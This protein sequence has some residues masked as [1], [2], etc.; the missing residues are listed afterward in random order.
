M[1]GV[2]ETNDTVGTQGSERIRVLLAD[3]HPAMR[4]G[5]RTILEKTSGIEVVGEAGDG[6]EVR[7]LAE[8]LCPQVL[9]L[10][11]RM[12]GPRPEETVAWVR[13]YCPETAVLVLT[14]HD[15]DAYLAAMM[16]AGIAGFVVKEEVPEKIVDAVQ[17]AARKQMI[18]TGEQLA[19]ARRWREEVGARWESLT[20]RERE[21]LALVV[22]GQSTRQIAEA[23]TIETCTV[24]THIGNILAKLNVASRAE[25]VAWMWKH[26]VVG[27]TADP[28]GLISQSW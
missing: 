19:R 10:D 5:I 6:E 9:L 3:D 14:A 12:P 1:T 17:R 13:A 20:E 23:L 27:Q 7:R 4:A 8:E 22:S 16:G 28:D 18:L 25:A 24:E 15:V 11:L 21:V 26:G 2:N